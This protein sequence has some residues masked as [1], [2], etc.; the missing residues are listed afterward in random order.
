MLPEPVITLIKVLM[1]TI[2]ILLVIGIIF[3]NKNDR[4]GPTHNPNDFPPVPPIV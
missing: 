1:I 2:G 4:S 3:G